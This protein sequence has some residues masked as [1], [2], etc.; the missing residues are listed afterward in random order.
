ME[1]SGIL[2]LAAGFDRLVQQHLSPRAKSTWQ[3]A[4]SNA[5]VKPAPRPPSGGNLTQTTE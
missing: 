4:G 2:V 3:K 5:Q 1:G